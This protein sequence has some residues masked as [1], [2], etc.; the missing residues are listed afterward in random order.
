MVKINREYLDAALGAV[1][2]HTDALIENNKSRSHAARSA[3]QAVADGARAHLFWRINI[4]R[5]IM[6]FSVLVGLGLMVA[7]VLIALPGL[8]KALNEPSSNIPQSLNIRDEQVNDV[9]VNGTSRPWQSGPPVLP[10]VTESPIPAVI[11]PSYS[12]DTTSI[13]CIRNGSF[14]TSCRDTVVLQN[15]ATFL[16]TWRDGAANGEGTISFNDGGSIT[17]VWADGVLIEILGVT[18][19][20]ISPAITSSVTFFSSVSGS[21]INPLFGDVT[22]GHRFIK[23]NDPNWSFA[24]CYLSISDGVDSVL[25]DLSRASNFNAQISLY[26]YIPSSRLSRVEFERAQQSC[27]YQYSNF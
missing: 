26:D 25:V 15:G 7:L 23:S 8:I 5:G 27:N 9:S 24:Y 21:E 12:K 4:S 17:G 10:D 19:P 1:H 3:S 11:V 6:I 2:L 18:A 22:T 14:E 16:G 20:E 13:Q